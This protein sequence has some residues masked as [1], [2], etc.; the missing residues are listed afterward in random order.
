MLKNKIGGNQRV[1]R[2]FHLDMLI[3]KEVEV[4]FLIEESDE[5]SRQIMI[6][7][8]LER[9]SNPLSNSG[10]YLRN[11]DLQITLKTLKYKEYTEI[12]RIPRLLIKPDSYIEKQL[13]ESK[14]F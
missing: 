4:V 9:R 10:Y 14:L 12:E 5:K 3:G 8:I 11:S 1:S 2:K 7:D 13:K 6:T